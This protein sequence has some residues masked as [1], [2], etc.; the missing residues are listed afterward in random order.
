MQTVIASSAKVI[1]SSAASGG[2]G[3][4]FAPVLLPTDNNSLAA[5]PVVRAREAADDQRRDSKVNTYPEVCKRVHV[6]GFDDLLV[7]AL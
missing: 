6:K 4:T 7:G 1:E 3:A 5:K 2:K